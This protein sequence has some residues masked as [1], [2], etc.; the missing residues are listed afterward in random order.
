MTFGPSP[1]KPL[2]AQSKKSKQVLKGM[3][4]VSVHNDG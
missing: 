1:L 4:D 3:N 2:A